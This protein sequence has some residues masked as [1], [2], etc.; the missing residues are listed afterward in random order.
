MEQVKT[1]GNGYRTRL[2]AGTLRLFF[3]ASAW[4]AA[5][6][7]MRFGPKYFWNGAMVFTLLATGLD[8][9]VGLGL[10]LAHK[11]YLTNLDELQRKVYLEAFG[12]T[13]GVAVVV[14]VPMSLMDSYGFISFHAEIWHLI[15]LMSLTYAASV[16]YGN[17]RYR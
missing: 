15:V 8:L 14:G 12:I 5:T 10:I 11:T 9:A 16:V 17:L 1:S 13:A 3:W 2:A 4:V 7:L 6:A